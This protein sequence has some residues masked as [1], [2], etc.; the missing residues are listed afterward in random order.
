MQAPGFECLAFDP[1]SL[2]QN[3]LPTSEV[4]VGRCEVVQALVITLMVV[5]IDERLNL[6]FKVAWE[7]V[8]VQQDAVLQSLMPTLD[9]ALCLRM[10][11]CAADMVHVLV[12]QPFGQVTGDVAGA[13]V[14]Q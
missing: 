5:M 7:E 8:V 11:G 1:F 3:G 10:I 12:L 14:G 2:Q 4:D 9:L 13:V 6:G